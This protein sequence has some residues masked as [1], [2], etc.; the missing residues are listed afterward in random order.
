MLRHRP[1]APHLGRAA[2]YEA[3]LDSS[4]LDP[5]RSPLQHAVDGLRRSGNMDAG[6]APAN[7][8]SKHTSKAFAFG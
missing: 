1:R 4:S 3:I 8:F 6:L 5:C 7:L 2:L